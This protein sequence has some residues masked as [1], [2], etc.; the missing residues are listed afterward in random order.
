MLAAIELP[1]KLCIIRWT[2]RVRLHVEVLTICGAKMDA[3]DGVVQIPDYVLTGRPVLS[4]SD[5]GGTGRRALK[6]CD[7]CKAALG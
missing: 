5:F 2:G 7:Q 3:A 6:I 4:L 1:E